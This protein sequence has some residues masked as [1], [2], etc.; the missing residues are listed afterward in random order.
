M[1]GSVSLRLDWYFF[2]FR[3]YNTHAIWGKPTWGAFWVWDARLT[4]MFILFLL[5]ISYSFLARGH[6]FKQYV[7]VSLLAV[8]GLINIPII[9]GSVEWWYTLHQPA[10]IRIFQKSALH[11][12]MAWPLW[13][14]VCAFFFYAVYLA[15]YR[16]KHLIEEF[17]E[18]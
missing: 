15:I 13:L 2:C 14:M 6:T 4:S 11:G 1:G 12:S 16:M 8:M 3:P 5:Y 17:S 10:T 7:P 9:K 18:Q